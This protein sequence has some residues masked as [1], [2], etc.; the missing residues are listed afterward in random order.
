MG[1]TSTPLVGRRRMTMRRD[2][3]E[4]GRGHG[5]ASEIRDPRE[6]KWMWLRGNEFLDD[7]TIEEPE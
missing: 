7:I 2:T 5:W 6:E 1:P 4:W 3:W